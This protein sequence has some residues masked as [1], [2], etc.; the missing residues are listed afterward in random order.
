MPAITPAII[1]DAV[2]DAISTSGASAIYISQSLR[3]HPRKY[4]ITLNGESIILWVYIWTLT[5][6]GRASLPN[7]YRI[8]M[9][10]VE[11]PLPLNPLGYTLLLGYYADLNIFAGFDLSRHRLF[12]TGSPSVQI[13]IETIRSAQQNGLSFSIKDNQE[14]AVGIRPDQFITYM[15]NSSELHKY[16]SDTVTTTLLSRAAELEV[17]TDQQ[18]QGIPDERKKL[19]STVSRLSR[20]ANFK[21][22][23]LTAY[24]N[25]C[26]ITGLQY[27]LVDAAHILPVSSSDSNDCVSNGVALSPTF[28]RAYDNGLIFLD[29]DYCFKLNSRKLAEYQ[30][31]RQNRNLEYIEAYMNRRIFLPHDTI[32][33][34]DIK[35]IRKAN[36]FR[37][38]IQ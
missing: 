28:H 17:I 25:A 32:Q 36:K 38:I 4:S 12:T 29:E 2:M 9:T 34:P 5:H 19:I 37:R 35:L 21:K 26:A 16:G 11:S 6:G 7:E 14:I 13:D 23:V 22:K 33:R 20:D 30:E 27:R 10:S 3:T 24:D 31:L 1:V 15:M 8:Q 18:M